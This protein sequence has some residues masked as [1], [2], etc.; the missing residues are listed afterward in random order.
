MAL[1]L[2]LL[3][4]LCSWFCSCPHAFPLQLAIKLSSQHVKKDLTYHHH[5]HHHRLNN[6]A[7]ASAVSGCGRSILDAMLH[8]PCWRLLRR[9]ALPARRHF[10]CGCRRGW[11]GA[12]ISFLE[13]PRPGC[14]S[15]GGKTTAR[16]RKA[17]CYLLCGYQNLTLG[18]N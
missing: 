18:R 17:S 14:H 11:S 8:S 4:L 12:G 7:V 1:L 6:S 2:L 10:P 3:L 13:R 5:H 16:R 9:P 15:P